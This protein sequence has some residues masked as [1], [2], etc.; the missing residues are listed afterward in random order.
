[1]G[2]QTQISGTIS[3]IT[4]E[5]LERF[6]ESRGLKKN[7]VVEQALLLFMEARREVPE[8][9][10]TPTRIVLE[11]KSFDHVTDLLTNPPPLNEA[12]RNLTRDAQD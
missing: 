5:R 11:D 3:S 10:F 12:L 8:E 7:F 2:R 1:M 9:A 4:K 6:C